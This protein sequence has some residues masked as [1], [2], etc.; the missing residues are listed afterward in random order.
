MVLSLADLV[1]RLAVSSMSSRW[2]NVPT[3]T[4]ERCALRPVD[5]RDLTWLRYGAFWCA[6]KSQ[7]TNRAAHLRWRRALN[8]KKADEL[9]IMGDAF[10]AVAVANTAY[11]VAGMS[12]GERHK[13]AI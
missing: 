12:C 4:G 2:I 13:V 9:L 6:G 7:Q 1:P 10:D 8:I 5:N 3:E 11:K